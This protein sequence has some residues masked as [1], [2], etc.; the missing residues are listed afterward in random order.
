MLNKREKAGSLLPMT[1]TEGVTVN[2]LPNE[3]YEYLMT[4]KEVANGYGTS[5][6]TILKNKLR[7]ENELVEGKHFVTAVQILN[8]K[9]WTNCPRDL[10]IPHNA[11]LWTKRGVVR[12]GF[13]MR[14]ER[15]KLF[16]DWAEELI[17]RF[18]E[19]CCRMAVSPPKQLPAV[20]RRHNRL[21][22]ERLVDILADV[23]KIDDKALRLSITNKLM[24]G[25]L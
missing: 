17:I 21:T 8:D 12:L 16:R 1:V 7:L 5:P 24:G 4:T 25:A 23:C 13:A 18:D 9:A 3:Q 10:N 19:E 20:R 11:I 22:Q 15:A 14:S 6:Y 2:V